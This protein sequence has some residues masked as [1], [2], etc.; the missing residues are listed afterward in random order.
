MANGL[1][2]RRGNFF[3]WSSSSSFFHMFNTN[4]NS[5]FALMVIVSVFDCQMPGIRIAIRNT[6][7]RKWVAF[8]RRDILV[9][10]IFHANFLLIFI[11]KNYF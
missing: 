5:L 6:S 3:F 8:H 1:S 11:Q 4:R 9:I 2:L 10:A 7:T